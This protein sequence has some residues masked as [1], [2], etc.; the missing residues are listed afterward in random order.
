MNDKDYIL[1]HKHCTNNRE[2]LLGS[3]QCG[4]FYCLRIYSPSDI[5]D[6]IDGGETAICAYCPVD[7]VIGSRSGYPMTKE[8]LQGMYDRWFGVTY[9]RA[10][11]KEKLKVR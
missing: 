2:E 8:F 6:W 11:A 4:C 3:E 10:E 5:N 7:S 9:S 1:A